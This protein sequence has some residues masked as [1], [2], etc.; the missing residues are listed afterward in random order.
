MKKTAD[1]LLKINL[2]IIFA[3]HITAGLAACFSQQL[4]VKIGSLLFGVQITL[5]EQ[6]QILVRYLG[7][8]GITF[9]VLMAFAAI[10]PVKNK[11]IIYG[12]IVYFCIR[13]LH[14]ILFWKLYV[15]FSTGPADPWIRLAL[16]GWFAVVLMVLVPR[17]Q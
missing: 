13:A 8:F 6:A 7:T 15:E 17:K 16:I 3:Y 9:A 4:A 12:G 5:T 2:W 1:I 11:K 14:R 10:D